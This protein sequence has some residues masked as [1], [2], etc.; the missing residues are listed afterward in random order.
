[1]ARKISCG[2]AVDTVPQ[3]CVSAYALPACCES[4]RTRVRFVKGMISTTHPTVVHHH[5]SVWL[6]AMNTTGGR[7][8]GNNGDHVGQAD[9][10]SIPDTDS[11]TAVQ[12]QA[13][14]R[15]TTRASDGAKDDKA[16]AGAQRPCG[17]Q[18]L[19]LS[20]NSQ[21]LAHHAL[22]GGCAATSAAAASSHKIPRSRPPPPCRSVA[23]AVVPCMQLARGPRRASRSHACRGCHEIVV[24]AVPPPST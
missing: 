23:A 9:Q 3:E 20:A 2:T 5:Q 19:A 18:N 16:P 1:M 14:R 12:H 17:R 8:D 11:V 13:L 6:S 21:G 24:T 7:P 22:R 10:P 4:F 15:R